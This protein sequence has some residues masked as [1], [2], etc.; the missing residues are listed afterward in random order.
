[1]CAC[2][3][4]G[5]VRKGS[6]WVIQFCSVGC[7]IVYKHNHVTVVFIDAIVIVMVVFLRLLISLFI[8]NGYNS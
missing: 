8:I 2:T 5:G 4:W 1:M 3:V 7:I 6:N